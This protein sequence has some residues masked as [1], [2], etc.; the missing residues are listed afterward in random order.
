MY[1]HGFGFK[2]VDEFAMRILYSYEENV[3][4][5]MWCFEFKLFSYGHEILRL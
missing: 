1:S 4:I 5:V 3:D 2:V